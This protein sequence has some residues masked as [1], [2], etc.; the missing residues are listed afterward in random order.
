MIPH[1]S[2]SFQ[3]QAGRVSLDRFIV[4]EDA[5][6]RSSQQ[7]SSN[8]QSQELRSQGT[9][10]LH[11]SLGSYINESQ[12]S[13]GV[14]RYE[15]MVASGRHLEIKDTMEAIRK[16]MTTLSTTVIAMQEKMNDSAEGMKQFTST[17]Q[18]IK[19][20]QDDHDQ[21]LK[22]IFET[23]TALRESGGAGNTHIPFNIV[24]NADASAEMECGD[25]MSP[26]SEDGISLDNYLSSK[27]QRTSTSA[28]RAPPMP[29]SSA[30]PDKSADTC[31]N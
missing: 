15:E 22:D 4:S 8:S 1:R 31:G 10:Q 21:V 16:T 24:L 29:K 23:L 19:N 27:R 2:N 12:N 6:K 28:E 3:K 26:L 13:S 18:D 9:T 30:K 5:T 20:R 25:S 17:I 11:S 14:G 7:L